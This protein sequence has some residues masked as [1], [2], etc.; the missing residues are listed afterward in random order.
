V[1]PFFLLRRLREQ[2]RQVVAVE[3]VVAE[4]ERDAIPADELLADEEGLREPPGLRL[5]GIGELDAPL[6]PV[7]RAGRKS[8][9]CPRAWR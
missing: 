3:Q 2:R 8:A 9:A 4:D 7:A 1:A 5:H 6:A